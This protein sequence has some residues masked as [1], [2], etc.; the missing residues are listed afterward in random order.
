MKNIHTFSDPKLFKLA[1]THPSMSKLGNIKSYERIEFLGDG[2]LGL[3][4][5]DLLYKT[6]PDLTEGKLANMLSNLIST[7]TLAE[8][9]LEI[10]INHAIIL[11]NGEEKSGGRT[12]PK[13]L[14]N[15]LEAI[16]GA[17][18]LDAGFDATYSIVEKLLHKRINNQDL[19]SKKDPKST[20]QE[21][22]QKNGKPIPIYSVINVIGEDHCP[23]FT[24]EVQVEGLP[25]ESAQGSSK[26]TAQ[27]LAAQ[28]LL[29]KIGI[30]I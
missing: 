7:N 4:V 15:A 28:N 26:K 2:V 17:I 1:M 30:I 11:D 19:I 13:N 27:I 12:N 8:V 10:G 16:I 24:I 5:S 29:N 25:A 22:A 23:I 9:A 20:L 3:I 14:E 18:Y 6:Y 21:W